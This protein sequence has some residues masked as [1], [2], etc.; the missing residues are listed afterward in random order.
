[1]AWVTRTPSAPAGPPGILTSIMFSFSRF[2]GTTTSPVPRGAFVIDRL[3]GEPPEPPPANVS[4]IEPDVRG[5]TTIREQLAKHRE[6]AVC[7]SCHKRIDPPGFALESFDVIGAQR[8][9]YRTRGSGKYV[10]KPRHPQAPKHFVQYRQGPNVD[11]SGMTANGQTFADIREYKRLLLKDESAMARSL[12]RLLLTYSLGR[13]LGFSDRPAIE[14]IV[15]RARS[16]DYGLRSIVHAVV[17][18]EIF[19]QP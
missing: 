11:A 9:W 4:A 6:H 7:A 18:S 14:R 1:M 8:D 10:K 3:L 5:T 13:H 17:Q 19:R 12:T 16:E 15:E 2:N